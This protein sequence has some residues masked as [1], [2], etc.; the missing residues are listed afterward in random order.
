MIERRIFALFFPTVVLEH[1]L[2]FIVVIP[3]FPNQPYIDFVSDAEESVCLPCFPSTDRRRLTSAFLYDGVDGTQPS[4]DA[5][6]LLDGRS[7]VGHG[8]N[9]EVQ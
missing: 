6:G 8:G 7:S 4:W 5:G 1:K 2:R 3:S 9:G